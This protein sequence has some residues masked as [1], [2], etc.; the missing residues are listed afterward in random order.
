MVEQ[1]ETMAQNFLISPPEKMVIDGD[2][3][4]NWEFFKDAWNNYAI[5]VELSKKD[6]AIQVATLLSVMGKDCLSV[7]KNLPMTEDEKKDPTEILKKLTEH[8]EPAKN[9]IY[10]CFSFNSCVQSK[11]TFDVFVSKLRQLAASCAYGALKEELIRDRIV[12]GIA[13]NALRERLL[14][15]KDLTLDKAI[16]MCRSSEITSLQLQKMTLTE[17]VHYVK[18][19]QKRRKPMIKNCSFCSESHERR[20]CPA[21]GHVC[22]ICHRE[23]HYEKTCRNAPQDTAQR[24]KPK[25]KN[26]SGRRKTYMVQEENSSESEVDSSYAVSI[27]TQ[28]KA[29][30]TDVRVKSPDTGNYTVI[31]FLLDSASTRSTMKLE[32]YHKLTSEMPEKTNKKLRMY[33]NELMMP[34]GHARLKCKVNNRTLYLHVDVVREAPISLLSGRAC[35]AFGLMQIDIDV[36]YRVTE[37]NLT[38][39]RVNKDYKD[40]FSGRGD[41]GQYHIEM[42]KS[43]KPKK[44]HARIPA[45]LKEEV[46]AKLK[47]L[48][49]DGIIAKVKQPTDWINSMVAVKKPNK[50]RIC[51]DPANLNAAIKRNHYPT[52]TIDDVM[53][54][55]TKARVFS[56]ADAKDGFLQVSLDGESSYITTFY[57]PFGLYRWLRM[58]FGIKSAPEEFQRRLDERLEGLENVAVIVDDILIYGTGETNEEAEKSHDDAL[59]ALLERCREKGIKLNQ[60][61]LRFELDS[62]TYMGHVF[63]KNGVRADPEKVLAITQMNRPEDVKAVQ[64]L[65]GV[66]TYLGKFVPKL[67]TVSEPLRRLTDKD[68]VFEWMQQ[69]EEAFNEVKKLLA[70]APV[71]KYYDVNEPVI[72]ESDSSD[73]GL[74]AVIMQSGKPIAYA[75]RTL[76]STERNYAQIEKEAL[77]L[78][79]AAERFEHYILGKSN[80]VM[81]TDHKP[82]ETI[83]KKP[84]LQCPKR[85][86]RMRLRLQKFDVSV[87][88]KPGPTMFISDTL[89]RAAL[90]L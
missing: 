46:W 61:K 83:F 3:A 76:T 11:D 29:Y 16:L 34:V 87:Q 73:V 28:K 48:E 57:T 60:K 41:L 49:R 5:A 79:F 19:K 69:H 38:K 50:L 32:D 78:V 1:K 44:N 18:N 42:D 58:P 21:Y 71:L 27:A 74:G 8:F 10:E 25:I 65:L 33:N 17:D 15:E 90:P 85:L 66:V 67:S 39:E 7:F 2:V 23:N 37:E 52:P 80:V 26:K 51:I 31:K 89:S 81:F 13:D 45:P 24:D 56:V 64:R 47:L 72:L 68:S 54:K 20:K 22:S 59:I 88:Y 12:I 86:Q 14:R 43:V 62:V 40:V 55:L 30:Y 53:P 63:S 6:N 82:L 9:T 36:V 77:S 75:S 84:I 4:G 35:E 70:A